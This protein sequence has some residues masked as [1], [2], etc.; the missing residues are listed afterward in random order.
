LIAN[1]FTR[2]RLNGSIAEQGRVHGGEVVGDQWGEAH[3]GEDVALE[4]DSRCNFDQAQA[5]VVEFEHGA[6]GDVEDL[7]AAFD[8]VFTA[9][10]QVLDPFDELARW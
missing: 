3:V 8:S 4:V 7:L 5:A 10:R 6:F 9:E 2:P 1:A